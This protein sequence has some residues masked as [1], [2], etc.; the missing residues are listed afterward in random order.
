MKLNENNVILLNS[1]DK[2]VS[3]FLKIN[4]KETQTLLQIH[5]LQSSEKQFFPARTSKVANLELTQLDPSL[6]KLNFG[7]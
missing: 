3:V 2:S 4:L 7:N 6:N 1:F 5:I